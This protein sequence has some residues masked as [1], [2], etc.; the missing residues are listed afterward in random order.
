[1]ASGREGSACCRLSGRTVGG[2]PNRAAVAAL[3]SRFGIAASA[4][5]GALGLGRLC[6]GLGLCR[7]RV[8][9]GLAG[10]V[11]LGIGVLDRRL[12]VGFS[13]GSG[14]RLFRRDARLLAALRR[15][16]IG[17]GCDCRNQRGAALGRTGI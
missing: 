16:L 13:P 9:R 5:A 15:L 14:I 7:L 6:R 4:L 2:W 1:M 8:A 11:R 17:I 3:T 10:S 12:G